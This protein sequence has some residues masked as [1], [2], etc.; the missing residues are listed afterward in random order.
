MK[1]KCPKC[2]YEF[3]T[4]GNTQKILESIRKGDM[5]ISDLSK[6][7]NISRPS[8]YHHIEKLR[9]QGLIEEYFKDTKG[10]PH[11]IR[12]KNNGLIYRK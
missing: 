2:G 12:I 5:K 11:F 9:Q 8:V 3:Q 10:K 4:K 1:C 6:E 7:I